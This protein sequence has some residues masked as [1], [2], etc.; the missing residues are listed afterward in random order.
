MNSSRQSLCSSQHG[1]VFSALTRGQVCV[2][3]GELM[4]TSEWT[5]HGVAPGPA[6][7]GTSSLT[8]RAVR[9]STQPRVG[10]LGCQATVP[11]FVRNRAVPFLGKCAQGA[12]TSSGVFLSA[13]GRGHG[14]LSSAALHTAC[15]YASHWSG[16]VTFVP[17]CPFSSHS[18]PR[19]LC[20]QGT[21]P[22]R[23]E[24]GGPLCQR[25]P[26]HLPSCHFGECA[27]VR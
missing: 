1:L 26:Q 15:R 12:T 2:Q 14:P 3:G 5:Q 8:A 23:T 19:A 21:D 25:P 11:G 24:L 6:S 9:A 20:L 17:A 7:P 22:H 16:R 4:R 27:A 13:P 18:E 10:P